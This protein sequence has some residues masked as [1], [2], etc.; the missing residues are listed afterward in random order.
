MLRLNCFFRVGEGKKDLALEAAKRLTEESL[1]QDGCISYDI[2]VSATREDVLMIC[3][4]WRDAEALKAHADSD[5][6]KREVAILNDCGEMKL[7]QFPF[8]SN[9]RD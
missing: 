1:R 8:P 4:T 6:F 7:E 9:E 3:E 5:V 2:Y